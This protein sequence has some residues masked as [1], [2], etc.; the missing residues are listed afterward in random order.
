MSDFT[1][2]AVVVALG[3]AN[4]FLFVFMDKWVVSR[5]DAI[6]SGAIGG[7]P[8]P[9]KHRRYRLR[10]QIVVNSG[11]VIGVEAILAFGWMLIGRNSGSGGIQ[12]FAYLFAFLDAL[13]AIGWLAT[14]PTHYGYLSSIVREAEEG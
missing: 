9:V 1:A 14:L 12:M 6:A 7:F 11:A 4:A 5:S 3:I 13:A 2:L 10:A 8:S